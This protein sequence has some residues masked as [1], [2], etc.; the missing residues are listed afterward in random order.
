MG[1]GQLGTAFWTPPGKAWEK[2]AV[3][4]SMGSEMFAP[5]AGIRTE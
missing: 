2:I 1:K 4:I 5:Q 3:E